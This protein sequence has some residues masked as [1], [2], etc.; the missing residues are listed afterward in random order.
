MTL[1]AEKEQYKLLGINVT[2]HGR[3]FTAVKYR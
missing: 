3:N 2:A 1:S